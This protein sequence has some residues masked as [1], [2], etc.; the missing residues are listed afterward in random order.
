MARL[1]GIGVV[2]L[3]NTIHHSPNVYLAT[4]LLRRA[5]A[6]ALELSEGY[7]ARTAARWLAKPPRPFRAE[8]KD[9]E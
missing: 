4:V 1:K 3:Y 5:S 7:A 2:T 8:L 9:F 6:V